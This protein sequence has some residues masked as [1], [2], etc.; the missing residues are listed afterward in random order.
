MAPSTTGLVTVEEFRNI[1]DP[2]GV[3]LELHNGE[4]VEVTRPKHKHWKI[5]KRLMLLFDKILGQ[6]GEAGL[7]FPFRPRLDHELRVA[8]VSWTRSDRYEQIDDDDNLLG[9]PDI[10]V[11]ILSP[12]NSASEMVEKR[13][14][15]LSTGCREFWIVDPKRG[16]IEVTPVHAGPHVYRG[17]EGIAIGN[18]TRS[19]DEILGKAPSR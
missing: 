1:E 2:P 18:E 10:V 7:E 13:D 17:S 12:S 4:V 11:E 15:C 8:D 16:F 19:V 3:R 14:L 9:A 5:Q 6:D